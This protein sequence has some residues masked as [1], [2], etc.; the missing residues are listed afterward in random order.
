MNLL[1]TENSPFLVGDSECLVIFVSLVGDLLVSGVLDDD[2]V[3]VKNKSVG[4][5]KSMAS[6]DPGAFGQMVASWD[7]NKK[8]LLEDA[9]K[10]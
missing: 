5:L 1:V 6:Q 9:M 3:E 7:D 10:S 4:I 2:G 8:F